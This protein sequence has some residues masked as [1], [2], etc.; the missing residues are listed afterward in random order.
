MHI[1]SVTVRGFRS[2]HDQRV[3]LGRLSYS[4][5]RNN[6]GKSNLI[7]ALRFLLEGGKLT[8][9]DFY[10]SGDQQVTNVLVYAVFADVQV[11]IEELGKAN[12][13]K[14]AQYVDGGKLVVRRLATRENL[15]PKIELQ[16]P[17]DP[18][19]WSTP[20]GID[21]ALKVLFPTVVSLETFKDPN[22]ELG[23]KS[24]ASL[25]KLIKTASASVASN[26]G[27]LR[28]ALRNIDSKL[29]ATDGGDERADQIIK[30][31][32]DINAKL[33]QFLSNQRIRLHF[34]LPQM[35]DLISKASIRIGSPESGWFE[36]GQQGQ[37]FQRLMVFALLTV[38]SERL[39]DDQSPLLILFEE[40]E[41]LII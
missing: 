41:S 19:M 31:E 33:E 30:I 25:Q 5:G 26:L 8:I 34:G 24:T 15:G 9:D 35:N 23:S 16:D 3:N 2:I 14:L 13:T 29:N 27:D 6:A 20:T 18:R 40:P 10:R 22:D 39:N 32:E 21:A 17:G 12:Q 11:A 1:Q 36:T 4:I 28:D 38:L 37:G 7:S